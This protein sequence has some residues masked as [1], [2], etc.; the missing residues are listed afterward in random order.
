MTGGTS[1]G[2][3][4]AAVMSYLARSESLSPP[5]TGT[6]L[7][8]PPLL[9]ESVVPA[10]YQSLYLSRKQNLNAPVVDKNGIELMTST[11]Q[12]DDNSP[13]YA[14]FNHPDGHARL[15]PMYMQVC[16]LDPLRDEGLLYERVL[17]EA[18]VQTKLDVYP[19]LPHAFWALYP[20]FKDSPGVAA[21]TM[22]GVAWLLEAGKDRATA[23]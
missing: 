22:K 3:N 16:G 10:K 2:A 17:R 14:C 23:K 7:S 8:V 4:I 1:A 6:F 15:P 9:P 11:Y 21:D 18:G 20:Q 19:G 5:L 12:A 13:L